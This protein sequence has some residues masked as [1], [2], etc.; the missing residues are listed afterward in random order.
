MRN[1]G[2]TFPE[3]M[4]ILFIIGVVLIA[5]LKMTSDYI[6]SLVFAKELF[7]LESAL[8]E[9]YQLLIAYRN[10]WLEQDFTL[11]GPQ[12]STSNFFSG[13]Y[14]IVFSAGSINLSSGSNCSYRFLNG[15]SS[16]IIYTVNLSVSG[17]L[18]SVNIK[19]SLPLYKFNTQLS[20]FLTRWHPFL[21]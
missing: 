13:N 12:G 6:R 16:T 5:F 19:G 1:E 20:G 21:Q 7:I 9:K 14:C 11:S 17:D 10:K 3:M 2:T 15:A 4:I 18:T 8:Q